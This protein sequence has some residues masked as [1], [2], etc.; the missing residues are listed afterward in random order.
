MYSTQRRGCS[1]TPN[2][3]SPT[4]AARSSATL[5]ASSQPGRGNQAHGSN[6]PRRISFL[7]RAHPSWAGAGVP[8][9]ARQVQSCCGY[10]GRGLA[11]QDGHKARPGRHY[12]DE[13]PAEPRRRGAAHQDGGRRRAGYELDRLTGSRHDESV[14]LKGPDMNEQRDLEGLSA[15]VTGATSGIGRT[16]AEHLAR[17]GAELVV[18]GRDAT[19]GSAVVDRITAEGGKAR[20]MAADLSDPAEL[21][22]LAEQAGPVDVLCN[23]AGFSWFGPTAHLDA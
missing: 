17:N 19:R 15:L 18:H 2:P 22:D 1:S 13:H 14:N 20:F 3:S 7:R 4:T 11:P 9:A 21:D 23:N 8:P 16:V 10:P 5:P 6:G 12:R